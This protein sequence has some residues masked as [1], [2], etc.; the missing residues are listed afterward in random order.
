M[1]MFLIPATLANESGIYN[2]YR[3]YQ[4]FSYM[5]QFH[6]GVIDGFIINTIGMRINETVVF[7]VDPDRGYGP[8]DP[9][10]VVTVPRY[11]NKSFYE[12]IP[13]SYLEDQGINISNGT[14]FGTAYGDVFITDFN[15]EN[16]TLFYILFPGHS[17]VLNGVPQVINSTD[18]DAFIATIEYMLQE[19][20]T[21]VLPNP[22]TGAATNYKVIGKTDQNITLDPNHPLANETLTFQVTLI[23]A[24]RPS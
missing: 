22:K 21:Y 23:D 14:A 1:E 20:Q 16:V 15:E 9:S 4:P 6:Q 13:R 18:T 11:Y 19:N 17:F 8:Y 2:P 3:T 7:H 12:E 10:K 24:V 5:V